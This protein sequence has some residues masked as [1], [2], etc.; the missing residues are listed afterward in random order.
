MQRWTFALVLLCCGGFALAGDTPKSNPA[1]ETDLRIELLSRVKTDQGTRNAL[2]AWLNEHDKWGAF[3][4]AT[5]SAERKAEYQKIEDAVKRADQENTDRL[6][7][8]VEKYGWPSTTLVGKDGAHAAWLL[9]QHADATPKFQRMCLDLMAKL[10]KNEVSQTDLAYLTDRV[11][12]AEG[13]KQIYG[14]QF[15]FAHGKQVPRPL[16]DAAHVDKRRAE[17]GLRP[18][19][20]YVKDLEST[21]G[22]P[23]KNRKAH[24]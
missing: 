6:V 23:P 20:E 21:Y 18:L 17:V 15:T 9:V 8:I 10:P 1:Q 5:L 4:P 3:N 16:E 7:T 13:K 22:G 11:L 12:L 24:P 19:A 2:V 14:T